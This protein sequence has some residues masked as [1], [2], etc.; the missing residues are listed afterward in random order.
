MADLWR[1]RRRHPDV[2]AVIP[3]HTLARAA[4]EAHLEKIGPR[5]SEWGW[6]TTWVGEVQLRVDATGIRADR[7]IDPYVVDLDFS[8]YD[9][10]PPR[11]QFV[12]PDP[13]GQRPSI[14]SRWWPRFDGTPPFEFALHH[15]YLYDNGT[16]SGQ[17]VCFSHSRD[18]YKSDHSPQ[19]S[20]RWQQGKHTV[21]ATLTRLRH[22]LTA[23]YYQGPSGADPV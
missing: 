11:V 5:L 22:V 9:I 16:R 20:Q 2:A 4:A 21:A 8:T 19:P 18:Y 3:A 15:E 1:D 23:P 13:Y 6:Q 7:Q 14:T 10:E 12:L 17:L